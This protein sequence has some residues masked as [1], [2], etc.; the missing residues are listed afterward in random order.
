MIESTQDFLPYGRQTI[1]EADIAAVTAVLRGDW[2][3]CG[4]MVSQFEQ[5]LA[6]RVGAEWAVVCSSGTAALHLAVLALG[7]GAGDGVIVPALTFLATANAV[8]FVGA[9]VV[10]ADV[11]P[12]TGLLGLSEF[13]VALARADHAGVT[14][15]AV[16]PV[17]LNGQLCP[18][19]P[20]I[21]ALATSR[22]MAVVEDGCHALGSVVAL[23]TGEV[24]R[25][26]D[27]HDA[28]MTV[29][30]F[31]PVK[32]IAMGEGGAVVTN[33]AVLQARLANLRTHG[34][35]REP[36]QWATQALAFS[37]DG[38]ANPW[39]YEMQELGFNY[40]ASDLHCALGLSQL[41]KLDH[42]ITQRSRLVARY[43]HLLTS[44]APQLRLLGRVS[45]CSPAWHLYVVFIDFVALGLSRAQFMARLKAQGVGS[46][47]HY[48]PLHLHP[49]YQ[50]RYGPL[51][52]PNAEAYYDRCL[53]LPL[54]PS[55]TDGELE[56]V[57]RAIGNAMQ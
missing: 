2:L 44:F 28:D 41:G 23:P 13:H 39:Y 17:H 50:N 47:V 15:R 38:E 9:E 25:V 1:D 19:L 5:A 6:T 4:P 34:M 55:L 22:G 21:R 32:T 18:D 45:G 51:S 43:D 33:S 52:L 8:R 56:R 42:F 30:S 11:N 48:L 27:C 10:F 40:R 16:F 57:V 54:Y 53:S 49:Y 36:D 46:Q 26:G 20:A 31:H 37:S 3:T 24:V 14:V 12:D 35:I 7:L 29:F